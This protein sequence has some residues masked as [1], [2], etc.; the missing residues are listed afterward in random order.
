MKVTSVAFCANG[1]NF[2]IGD[3]NGGLGMFKTD[4][5][6][7][8]VVIKYVHYLTGKSTSTQAVTLYCKALW[9]KYQ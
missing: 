4:S 5:N 6:L 8:K 3:E 9:Q 7:R 1:N 2:M